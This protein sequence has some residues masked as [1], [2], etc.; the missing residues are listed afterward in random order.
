MTSE[1][2]A[3]IAVTKSSLG[4]ADVVSGEVQL[5]AAASR[6]KAANHALSPRTALMLFMLFCVNDRLLVDRA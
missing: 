6:S 3:A 1:G 4:E 2:M 5:M